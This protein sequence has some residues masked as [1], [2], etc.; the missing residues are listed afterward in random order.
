M[1]TTAAEGD[2]RPIAAE[3]PP[4]VVHIFG[5]SQVVN[6]H[7]RPLRFA[8]RYNACTAPKVPVPGGKRLCLERKSYNKAAQNARRRGFAYDDCRK[9][10]ADSKR[11]GDRS[12]QAGLDGGFATAAGQDR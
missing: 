3:R 11:R 2:V 9:A 8:E 12:R 7:G 5:R 1:W 6:P 10:A 4:A